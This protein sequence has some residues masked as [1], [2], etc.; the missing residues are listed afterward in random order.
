[1]PSRCLRFENNTAF[2][3]DVSNKTCGSELFNKNRTVTC[4]RF[5]YED[6]KITI[7]QD[8]RKLIS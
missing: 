6:E 1:M 5:V 4:D 8:V 3:S 2:S 7:T